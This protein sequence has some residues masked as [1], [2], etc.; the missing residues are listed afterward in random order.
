METAPN[1]FWNCYNSGCFT[2]WSLW[3][4]RIQRTRTCSPRGDSL[5]QLLCLH[6]SYSLRHLEFPHRMYRQLRGCQ[7]FRFL[8]GTFGT[9]NSLRMGSTPKHRRFPTGKWSKCCRFCSDRQS[10]SILSIY[11]LPASYRGTPESGQSRG[12]EWP[13]L[14]T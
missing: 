10:T 7:R 12:R 6:P 4:S 11:K 13:H 8:V 2:V 5:V 3:R 1:V 9:Q 14:C